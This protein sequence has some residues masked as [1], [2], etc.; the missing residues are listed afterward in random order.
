MAATHN[1][2]KYQIL[3]KKRLELKKNVLKFIYYPVFETL[4]ILITKN[5]KFYS[6]LSSKSYL[7]EQYQV[8]PSSMEFSNEIT[9]SA[10][11]DSW[12]RSLFSPH[13]ARHVDALKVSASGLT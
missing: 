8:Q 12:S 1:S 4:Y 11:D 6:F 13:A 5:L 2:A 10:A 9:A 3:K 7:P